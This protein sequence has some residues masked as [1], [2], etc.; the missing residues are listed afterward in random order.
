MQRLEGQ[1]GVALT[2][3]DKHTS[4]ASTTWYNSGV[5][6]VWSGTPRQ[7]AGRE[8]PYSTVGDRYAALRI[9]QS[10]PHWLAVGCAEPRR[11]NESREP[12]MG[13]GWRVLSTRMKNRWW[14]D[15]VCWATWSR[16]VCRLPSAGSIAPRELPRGPCDVRG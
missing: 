5:C 2:E 13:P 16:R 8:L 11:A 6:H 4:G 10:T 7:D 12:G 9:A 15:L 3:V 14:L 1:G